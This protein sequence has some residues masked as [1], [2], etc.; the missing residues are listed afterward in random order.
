VQGLLGVLLLLLVAGAAALSY[1]VLLPGNWT[2]L[3]LCCGASLLSTAGVRELFMGNSTRRLAWAMIVAPIVATATA[4]SVETWLAPTSA[5]VTG[6]IT[7]V[8]GVGLYLSVA[9]N[10][11][12]HRGRAS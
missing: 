11:F 12:D 5:W 4:Y 1:L 7:G 10:P 2:A 3:A 6:V 9:G 8:V